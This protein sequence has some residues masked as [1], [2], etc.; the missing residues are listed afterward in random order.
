[1]IVDRGYRGKKQV[2][3]VKISL[4][5]VA[6]KRDSEREKELKRKKFRRRAA[7]EPLIGHL[8]SDFRLGRN[9]LKGKLGDH[10][11]ALLSAIAWNLRKWM[12]FFFVLIF[13]D[14]FLKKTK[15]ILN[16]LNLFELEFNSQIRKRI[17]PTIIS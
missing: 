4:P 14:R 3:G 7:I 16:Q 10:M 11:N 2:R 9:F 15:I 1:M 8:K 17:T 12:R 13:G 6:L 5:G